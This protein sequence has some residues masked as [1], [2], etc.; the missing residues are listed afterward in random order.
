MQCIQRIILQQNYYKLLPS[1]KQENSS[2]SFRD[3]ILIWDYKT[4]YVKKRLE[5]KEYTIQFFQSA[6]SL[7]I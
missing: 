4:M 2:K 7:L 6:S 5:T 3:Y 1:L